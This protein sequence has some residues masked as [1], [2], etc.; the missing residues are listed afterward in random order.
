V[1]PAARAR[2]RELV[3]RRN[4]AIITCEHC[5]FTVTV[6]RQSPSQP[7]PQF[8]SPVCRL[9]HRAVPPRI[10]A[11]QRHREAW[12]MADQQRRSGRRMKKKKTSWTQARPP[13]RL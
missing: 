6:A 9:E 5:A 3:F 2:R 4:R 1:L 12:R 13:D 10:M 8:C 11:R 7:W